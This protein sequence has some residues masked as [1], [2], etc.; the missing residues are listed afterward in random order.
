MALIKEPCEVFILENVDPCGLHYWILALCCDWAL[1][2]HPINV[3]SLVLCTEVVMPEGIYY[4]D[5]AQV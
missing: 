5:I 2:K 1:S 3:K 4:S